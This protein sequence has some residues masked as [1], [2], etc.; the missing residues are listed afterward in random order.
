M[1]KFLQVKRKPL[2]FEVVEPIN[3]PSFL[4]YPNS[5]TTQNLKEEISEL[6]PKKI[7]DK[8]FTAEMLQ[9]CYEKNAS[10]KMKSTTTTTPDQSIH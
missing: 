7:T 4:L 6:T 8:A 1:I 2:S 9:D 3:F 5:A 10:S